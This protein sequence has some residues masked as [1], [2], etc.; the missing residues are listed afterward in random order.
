[1]LTPTTPALPTMFPPAPGAS[2]PGAP[3]LD[4]LYAKYNR[5]VHLRCRRLL[6]N[7][8]AAED[9]VQETFVRLWR[10]LPRVPAG[11][12]AL[13]W[14]Y[15]VATNYCLNELRNQKHRARPCGDLPL[16][17]A[18]EDLTDD[19]IADRDLARRMVR[20]APARLRNAAWLYHVDGF[21][22][23]EVARILG[24]SRRTVVS[25]L[26]DFAEL[27]RRFTSHQVA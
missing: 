12:A 22:Q 13:M 11:T 14:I 27:S 24:I 23:A 20:D 9:A 6:G 25:V 19:R 17:A 7:A 10:H 18:A 4:D 1:M 26:G 2:S 16:L 5:A 21:D 8:V 15:R 3:S